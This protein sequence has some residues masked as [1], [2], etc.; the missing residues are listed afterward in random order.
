MFDGKKIFILG[1]ARSGYEVA[2]ILGERKCQLLLNDKKEEA[3]QNKEQVEELKKLGVELV[4]G[5][6]PEDLL[7]ESYDYVIKNPGISNNHFYIQKANSLHI[8]VL[9]EVEVAYQPDFR[10]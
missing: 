6:H 1:M 4:F 10:S 8:P 9:N 5:S 3:L 7:D 2:K